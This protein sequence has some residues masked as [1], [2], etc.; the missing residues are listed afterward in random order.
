[1][2]EIVVGR[3]ESD[4]K[5]YGED[6]TILLG[7]HIV[8]TGEEVHLTTPLLL[9][10]LRPHII[11]LTGKR[12]EGKCLHADTLVRMEDNSLVMIKD[13]ENVDKKILALNSEGKLVAAEKTN[14][15]RRT[16]SEMLLLRLKNGG[17]I[18][19]TPE[20]P[21]LTQ[22]GWKPASEIP[23]NGKIAVVNFS[24]N[25]DSGRILMSQTVIYDEIVSSELLTGEFD[26]CDISVPEHHNFV[27]NNIIVHNSYSLGIMMEEIMK[28]PQHIRKNLCS[29]VID[30]QGIFWTMK[31]PNDKEY[32]S[33][34]DWGLQPR[35]FETFVYVP[36]GQA[37]IFARAGVEFD[38]TFS[39]RADQMS[40]D[41]WIG[42]FGIDPNKPLGILLQKSFRKLRERHDIDDIVSELQQ[43]AGFEHEKLALQNMFLAAKNWGIFGDEKMPAV[44]E[45]G[46]TTIID[47]S[48]TP[49]NVRAL[50][51]SIVSKKILEERVTARRK[52]E[53]AET[54]LEKIERTPMPWLF[55]DE[56][57]NF[58]PAV[59]K[60]PATDVLS[61]IVKEG[62][63][64]GIT[65]VLATQQPERLS[66][67]ALSQADM[68]ISFRLTSKGDVDALKSIMQTYLL[69]DIGKYIN[70]LPRVK[71]AGI[72]LDDNS[73]RIYKV[74]IRPRQSWH[75]GSSPV[76]I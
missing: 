73:E 53:L 45:P 47:V 13:L 15:Y 14:F 27:A 58:L 26:V 71:G 62:R 57:H 36:E 70:E 34:N 28:L 4:L 12:G 33:L 46:R 76:A 72:I 16:V 74:R 10:V 31:S 64:P 21:L 42:V 11:V 66:S 2:A 69:F 55:I 38:S 40:A 5:R 8:G 63:Q 37:D 19:L 29:L 25:E 68:V 22:N 48:L 17:E 9:D 51:V 43:E 61:K 35:G 32:A 56:A 24:Q 1:M 7:K 3:D 6:G 39:M 52:E 49:Q 20:H 18:K 67:D 59:G 60:T 44:L 30:T 50:L 75:A 65:L 41:D 54:A 23:I